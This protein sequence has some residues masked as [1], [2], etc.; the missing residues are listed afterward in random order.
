MSSSSSCF[1]L[2]VD[3]WE[4]LPGAQVTRFSVNCQCAAYGL[5]LPLVAASLSS[6]FLV[7]CLRVAR[8]RF[9]RCLRYDSA[10]ICGRHS[11]S[12]TTHVSS[13]PRRSIFIE[14]RHRCP[15]VGHLPCFSVCGKKSRSKYSVLSKLCAR[16]ANAASGTT[17][18]DSLASARV[19][20][21]GCGIDIVRLT[22][23]RLF[24]VVISKKNNP[25][26]RLPSATGVSTSCIRSWRRS[27]GGHR[28]ARP[29]LN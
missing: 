22:D 29:C 10:D 17:Y 12:F 7:H 14:T 5:H 16:R 19:M 26:S 20:S 6:I 4:E 27:R 3:A 28:D 1:L 15:L 2:R 23:V 11:L 25:R 8:W 18:P 21:V 9:R 13:P 24:S